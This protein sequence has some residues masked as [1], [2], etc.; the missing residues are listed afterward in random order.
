MNMIALVLRGF[1]SVTSYG[2]LAMM[3]ALP[4]VSRATIVYSNFA[5]SFGYDTLDGNEVGNDLASDNLAEADTFTPTSTLDL[6]SIEIPLS[7]LNTGLC[8]NNFSVEITTDTGS[9]PGVP[10]TSS[11]LASI[12]VTGS[13]LPIFG[14]SG[15]L[16]LTYS[17]PTVALAAGTQYWIVV[18]PDAGGADQIEWNWNTTG[19]SSASAT[20]AVGGGPS[21]TWFNLGSTPSAYEIDGTSSVP[22]PGTIGMM[23]AGGLLLGF[24]R[25]VRG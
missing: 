17:G 9:A 5:A 13:T 12:A 19:D 6:S 20:A 21:D 2:I 18:L 8:P 22:E 11:V 7:C 24:I 3:I 25:K 16:T 10:N 15:H 1:K 4:A 23:L 14:G